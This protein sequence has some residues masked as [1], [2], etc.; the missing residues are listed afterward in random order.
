MMAERGLIDIGVETTLG[1]QE[2][3]IFD[4]HGIVNRYVILDFDIVADHDIVADKHILT[5]RTTFADLRTGANMAPMPNACFSPDFARLSSTI[6]VA[7][8]MVCHG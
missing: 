5:Q 6:A 4:A 2:H 3:I 8:N 7:M 1:P